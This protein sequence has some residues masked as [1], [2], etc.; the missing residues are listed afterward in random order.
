MDK[1]FSVLAFIVALLLCWI[2]VRI[3]TG[4]WREKDKR[5]SERLRARVEYLERAYKAAVQSRNDAVEMMLRSHDILAISNKV[6][7]A[8]LKKLKAKVPA[9]MKSDGTVV[10]GR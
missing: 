1:V 3:E 10:T 2:I 5:T 6:L 9:S 4:A 8:E 7:Q